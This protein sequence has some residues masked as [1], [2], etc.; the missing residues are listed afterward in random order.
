VAKRPSEG[1]SFRDRSP[2]PLAFGE[3]LFAVI[4]QQA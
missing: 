1:S 3:G 2:K 4:D